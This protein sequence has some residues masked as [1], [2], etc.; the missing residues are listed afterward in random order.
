[1]INEPLNAVPLQMCVM[2]QDWVQQRV[3]SL[4]CDEP[5]RVCLNEFALFSLRVHI[6]RIMVKSDSLSAADE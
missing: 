2:K 5:F 6:S 1:M 3:V 4:V